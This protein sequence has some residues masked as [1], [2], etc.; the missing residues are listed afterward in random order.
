MLLSFVHPVSLAEYPHSETWTFMVYSCGDCDLEGYQLGYMTQMASV[1]STIDVDI[2]VQMDR[3]SGCSPA[4]GDWTDCKRF[5]VT[6]G[7]APT[8]E[9]AIASLGEVNMGDPATLASFLVWAVQAYPSDYYFL[10]LIG[11]GWL[12]GVCFD[13][14]N[15][16]SLSPLEIRWALSQVQNAT[17][18]EVNVIAI[19]GCQQAALEIAYEVGDF[20]GLFVA[21]E[22]VSTH[23]QYGLILSSLVNAHGTMN[24][25]AV[26]SMIVDYYA[27]YSGGTG[28]AI[29]TLSAFNLSRVTTDVVAAAGDLASLLLANITWYAHAVADAAARAESHAPLYSVELAAS[30]RDLYDFA[31]EVAE[32]ISDPSIQAAAQNLRNAIEN[33]CI[34]E[35]HGPGHPDFHG[36]YI[37]LPHNEA[38]YNA[39]TSIYGQ[40]YSTAHPL[41]TQDTPWDDLL[42]S[43][44][45]THALGVRSREQ[46]VTCS[47]MAFDSDS[48]NYLDA[49]HVTLNVS[50]DGTPIDVTARGFLI[51]PNGDVVDQHNCTWTASSV[52]GFGNVYLHMPSGGVA[53]LYSARVVVSDAHGVFEDEVLLPQVAF[54]PEEMR[55][56]VSAQDLSPT[57]TVVGQGYLTEVKV[58]VA[59]DGHYAESLNAK[60]YANETLVNVTQ[61]AVPAGSSAVFTVHWDTAG[62]ELGNYTVTLFVEPVDGEANTTDNSL[63]CGRM[64]CVSLPGDVDADRDVDIFDIVRLADAY[65]T[66]AGQPLYVD[67]CDINGNGDIDIFDIVLAAGNYGMSW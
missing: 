59:N 55:H 14:S 30:C 25:S 65:G 29:T 4:Y 67:N 16:D 31:L 33:A 17:G 10:M 13:W 51:D 48:D 32:G 38:V 39:R 6:E 50:T 35:W 1:G 52:G 36:L 63:Q 64:V 53:G 49:L 58:T 44:F 66:V 11:H 61:V 45:K 8:S 34:A 40:L 22:E 9:N 23:W 57:R 27:Q 20:P 42:F 19:E 56:A 26:A 28:G 3:I 24:C 62:W 7:L 15:N 18:V 5:Y 21:S 2:V 43:L 54:L 60:V 12:D 37:Y 47:S 46:I 41:W